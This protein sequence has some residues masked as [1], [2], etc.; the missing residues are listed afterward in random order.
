M[1]KVPSGVLEEAKK[2]NIPVVVIAGNVEDMYILNQA[3]F[4]GVFSVTPGPV[5]LEAA[6]QPEY[7]KE[8]IRNTTSQIISLLLSDSF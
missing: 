8:N 5:T 2:Q 7:A 3:G 1:G 4:R 6:M